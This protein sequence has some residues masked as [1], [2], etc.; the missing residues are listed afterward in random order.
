[1]SVHSSSSWLSFNVG[2]A[3]TNK[4]PVSFILP[5]S[6]TAIELSFYVLLLYSTTGKYFERPPW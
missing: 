1:M 3:M 2:F 5:D 4:A 6:F